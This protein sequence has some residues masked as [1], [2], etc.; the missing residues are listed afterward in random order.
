MKTQGCRH[1]RELYLDRSCTRQ[2]PGK[3]FPIC[4]VDRRYSRLGAPA[5]IQH[6]ADV[7]IESFR[8]DR[9]RT[10]HYANSTAYRI[11]ISRAA[12]IANPLLGSNFRTC[13]SRGPPACRASAILPA[14][15][16]ASGHRWPRIDPIGSSRLTD[17]PACV[18]KGRRSVCPSGNAPKSRRLFC[19]TSQACPAKI[20]LFPNGRNYDLKKSFPPTGGRSGRSSRNGEGMRWTQRRVR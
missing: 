19:P 13:R 6:K 10:T 16:G 8:H 15:A 18:A 4:D 7:A 17:V 12:R 11:E 9:G 3:A 20:F 2:L 1:R 5:S 14:P